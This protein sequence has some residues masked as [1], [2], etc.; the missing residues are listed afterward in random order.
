MKKS[1]LVFIAFGT[2]LTFALL[3]SIGI[4]VD[5]QDSVDYMS[6]DMQEIRSETSALQSRL[7]RVE[8][9]ISDLDSRIWNVEQRRR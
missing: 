7:W 6:S 2:V 1:E 8:G 5:T 4:A 9:D 3:L